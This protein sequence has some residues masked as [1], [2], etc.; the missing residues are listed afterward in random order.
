MRVTGDKE[1]ALALR[2]LGKGLPGTSIDSAMKSA[3]DPMLT[4][5][6]SR[7]RIHRQPGRRPK[8]GHLDE[9]IVFRKK[10]GATRRR[11]DY[12]IGGIKRARYLMSFLEFGTAPHFQPRRFGGIMHPGARPFPF[13]RPAFDAHSDD[14]TGRFGHE[15]WRHIALMAV[16]FNKGRK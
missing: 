9:G 3:A 14:I 15:I 13:M 8:G 2:A 12:V 1:L 4:D 16:A 11:R 6:I 5:A 10:K 7:A